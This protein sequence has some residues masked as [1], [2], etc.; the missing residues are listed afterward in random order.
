MKKTIT[1]LILAISILT[2]TA[3][4]GNAA[5]SVGVEST[6]VVAVANPEAEVVD[7]HSGSC[8]HT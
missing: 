1:Y 4:A 8:S 2:L 7:F 5:A 3:C 6:D